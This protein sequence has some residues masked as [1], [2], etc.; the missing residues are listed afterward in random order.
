MAA[1]LPFCSEVIGML[2]KVIRLNLDDLWLCLGVVTG[3][4]A[5]IQGVTAAVLLL[6][7]EHSSILISGTALPIAAGIMTLVVALGAMGVS[8]EQALRFGQTRRRTLGIEL[9]RSLF[10]GVCSM[11]LAALLTALERLAAPA[12]WLKLTGLPGLSL[13]GVPPMPEPSLGAPVDPAWES[14][15]FIEDFTLDWWWWP[16][17]L[18]LALVFGL[19]IGAVMQRFGARGAW[20][21]WA[22]WMA[23]CFGPQLVGRNAYFIG[24]M[25]QTVAVLCVAATAAGLV[26]S[27]WSLLHA[28]VRS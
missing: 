5:L 21:I 12:L 25:T 20:G 10:M 17:I 19:I 14:T 11:A 18:L 27:I 4:F 9:A 15:L 13:G 26:W 23:L 7:G 3:L 28:T 8:F 22:I 1:D 2:K 16:A 6:S 24:D